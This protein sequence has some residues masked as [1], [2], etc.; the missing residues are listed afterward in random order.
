M[1]RLLLKQGLLAEGRR[2]ERTIEWHPG[3]TVGEIRRAVG[4]VVP[5]RAVVAIDARPACNDEDLVPDG[6]TIVIAGLPG[7]SVIAVVVELIIYALISAAI[8]YAVMALTPKPKSPGQGQDR[9]EEDSPT[10]AWDGMQTSYGQGLPIPVVLGRHAAAGQ[11]IYSNT[12]FGLVPQPQY[13]TGEFLMLVLALSEGPIARIGGIAGERNL[14]GA[15]GA[16]QSSNGPLPRNVRVNDSLLDWTVPVP[17]VRMSLR[18]GTLGQSPMPQFPGAFTQI[19]IGLPLNEQNDEVTFTYVGTDAVGSL[20]VLITFFGGC[21]QQSANG[22]APYLVTWSIFWRKVGTTVWNS[23]FGGQTSSTN[24]FLGQFDTGTSIAFATPQEGPIE[25]RVRRNTSSGSSASVVSACVVRAAMIAYAQEFAYPGVALAGFELLA[26]GKFSGALPNFKVECDGILVRVWDPVL[27]FSDWTW[28]RPA[29]PFDFGRLD[30]PPGQNPAWILGELLTNKRWGLGND[31]GDDGVDWPALRRWAIFCEQNVTNWNEVAFQCAL[32]LD[33]KKPAWDAVLTICSAGRAAP[34]WIGGKVSVVYQFRDAHS[35]RDIT[36]PAKTPVQLIT[37]GMVEDVQVRWLQR[38]ERPTAFQFQFLDAS[39]GYVQDVVTV[40]DY[41]VPL[42]DPT[43]PDPEPWRP[44]VVQ[45]YGVTRRT[46]LEREGVFM[47][48]VNRLVER[49]LTFTAGPNTLAVTIGELFEFQAEILRP[50]GVDKAVAVQ[51]LQGGSGVD[52]LIVDHVVSGSGLSLAVRSEDGLPQFVDITTCTP[53]TFSGRAATSIDLSGSI[54]CNTGAT[55]VIGKTGKL[56]QTYQVVSITL[57]QD[58][59]RKVRAMQ[60][61]PEVFDDVPT[62]WFDETGSSFVD[63][64]TTTDTLLSQPDLSVTLP[65]AQSIVAVPI[66]RGCQRIQWTRPQARGGARGRV[67]LQE[68]SGWTMLGESAGEHL[69]VRGLV[70]FSTITVAVVLQDASGDFES[71]GAATQATLTLQE[72]AA[73]APPA[74]SNLTASQ[75]AGENVLVLGWDQAG[76]DGFDGYEVRCGSHW[77][78]ARTVYTGRLSE[79]RLRPPPGC[80]TYQVAARDRGGMFG[81]RAKITITLQ[82]VPSLGALMVNSTEYAPTGSGGTHSNTVLDSATEPAAPFIALSSGQLSGT[83]TSGT[84]DLGYRAPFFLRVAIDAQ[85]LDGAAVDEWTFA[86][87]SGEARWR[88][89]D[90]RPA[91]IGLPGTDWSTAVDDLLCTVDDLP[92]DFRASGNLGEPGSLTL[93]R[94]ESRTYDGTT[95]SAWAAHVDR[96]VTCSKWEARL[97]L[98]RSTTSQSVRARTLRME[99]LL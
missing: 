31:I 72:F 42:G 34:V 16:S 70:A 59:K 89:V 1:I 3:L 90:T 79:A 43:I 56:T 48:R 45:G 50:F 75:S 83:F 28:D 61:V 41:E 13:Q 60:W 23:G 58:L 35:D 18:P 11:V 92:A 95:W 76:F 86:I 6:S 5:D 68:D 17:G 10:Y 51:V 69:D 30:A 94:V 27:G 7:E 98:A 4:A 97:V 29:G 82:A 15:V 87:D 93:C 77:A 78:A 84:I 26:S 36:V 24:P 71:P 14:L 88:T 38:A 53:T 40:P 44:E 52:N 47:H 49:E 37:D 55:C 65:R 2:I 46:Q 22:P 9:G 12:T 64:S 62:E 99:T 96:S 67:Y 21:Y 54:D 63:L 74:P 8:S 66:D 73:W 25:V 19:Q 85:E 33:S 80:T 57:G 32:V 81:P 39:L 20:S 91:S